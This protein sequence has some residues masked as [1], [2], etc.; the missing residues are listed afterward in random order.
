MEFKEALQIWKNY[1]NET[2]DPLHYFKDKKINVEAFLKEFS[3][4]L[5][6]DINVYKDDDGVVR[7]KPYEEP[8]YRPDSK[9][10]EMI[11]GVEFDAKLAI[12][13]KG[14]LFIAKEHNENYGLDV[15]GGLVPISPSQLP[16]YRNPRFKKS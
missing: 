4:H 5:S 8:H 9:T 12:D 13:E 2:V 11:R 16:N 10:K 1:L 14:N 7:S 6:T 15:E 3:I